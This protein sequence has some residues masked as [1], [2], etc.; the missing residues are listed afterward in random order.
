MKAGQTPV[1]GQILE[2][3]TLGNS[4]IAKSV[5]VDT[6]AWALPGHL[7]EPYG[8]CGK[9]IYMGCIGDTH[10]GTAYVHPVK[11]SCDRAGCP[12]CSSSWRWKASK[13]IAY[14]VDEVRKILRGA[15]Y[16]A[17]RPIH[18]T[19]NPRPSEWDAFR[20]PK[21][22]PKLR[23]KAQ[24]VVRKAGFYGGVQ[25]FHPW[26]YRCAKCGS[27]FNFDTKTCAS[28][29]S[30]HKTRYWSPH[31]HM[32]GFGWISPVAEA[33]VKNH[34]VRDSV[35]A[36]A[37]YELGHCGIRGEYQAFTWFGVG[38]GNV[39]RRRFDDAVPRQLNETQHCPLCGQRLKRLAYHGTIPPPEADDYWPSPDWT[40]AQ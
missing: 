25:V 14:R 16:H 26:R 29:G 36:T 40:I 7:Y 2:E 23:R 31:W 11:R 12:V 21:R 6:G 19:V 32:L 15:G 24:R 13:R 4:S 27:H 28:C 18:V 22:Y 20:D 38:N 3:F 10:S 35:Q 9:V 8:D 1:R 34:G 30:D 17:T 39:L 37:Y 5:H 33:L